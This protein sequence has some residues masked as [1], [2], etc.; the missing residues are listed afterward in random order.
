MYAQSHGFNSANQWVT[1][2]AD[3]HSVRPDESAM[4][5]ATY[6]VTFRVIQKVPQMFS[7][8]LGNTSGMVA[9]RS[10]TAV[11][12]ASDCIYALNPTNY[13]GALSVGGSANL[14][15]SCGVY[16]NS[17][18]SCAISTNGGAVLSAPE[19]DVVGNV[20][21]QNPLT[22]PANT[23]VSP[24]SDPLAAP[25]GP[26]SAPYACSHIGTYSPNADTDFYPGVYCWGIH[27]PNA[28]YT[29][30]ANV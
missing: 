26:A 28:T 13:S 21:T 8:V 30:H 4:G 19:Y 17:T 25:P 18:N 9:A 16:V 11:I 1:Y 3:V 12:G 29:F 7:A 2:Q 14:T 27:V 10:T 5:T 22:P 20:C 23:G 6:W 15:S 24:A